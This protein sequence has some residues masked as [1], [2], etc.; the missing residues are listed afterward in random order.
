MFSSNYSCLLLSSFNWDDSSF[1]F[2]GK[3]FSLTL[4]KTT[5]APSAPTLKSGQTK[6][7]TILDNITAVSNCP[8]S[9]S[10]KSA[11]FSNSTCHQSR[12]WV[13]LLLSLNCFSGSVSVSSG[14]DLGGILIFYISYLFFQSIARLSIVV[15]IVNDV[16]YAS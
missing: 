5:H 15:S 2:R 14:S 8:A 3:Y 1:F 6:S 12:N 16:V 9:Y 11:G 7:L 10:R 4:R 13:M